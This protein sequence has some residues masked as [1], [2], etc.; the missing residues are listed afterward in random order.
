MKT[1]PSRR[2]GLAAVFARGVAAGT[3][4]SSKGSAIV[5]TH[6]P[7]QERA[8]RQSFFGYD[9]SDFLIVNGALFVMPRI[10]EEKR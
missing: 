10:I 5:A 8:S 9:H 7:A 2:T 4:A 6:H 3:I 1:K